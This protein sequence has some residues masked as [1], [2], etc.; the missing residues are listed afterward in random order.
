[1]ALATLESAVAQY[2]ANSLYDLNRS[3]SECRLFIEACRAMLIYLPKQ[4]KNGRAGAETYYNPEMVNQALAKAEQW[5]GANGT[6]ASG[7][8]GSITSL[9]LENYRG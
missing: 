4:V 1:M 5:Y 3:A 8:G 9:S 6:A 7:G 2:Q